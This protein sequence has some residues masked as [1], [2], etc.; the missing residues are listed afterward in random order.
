ME[1]A[2]RVYRT[3]VNYVEGRAPARQECQ[4]SQVQSARHNES[5][6]LFSALLGAPLPRHKLLS[7][8]WRRQNKDSALHFRALQ[9]VKKRHG[10]REQLGRRRHQ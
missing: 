7:G 6:V 8:G 4:K 2:P 3:L 1:Q 10:V 9:A 5:R